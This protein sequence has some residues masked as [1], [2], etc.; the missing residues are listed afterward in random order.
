M[1]S[2][3]MELALSANA[4][5]KTASMVVGWALFFTLGSLNGIA[6]TKS[7][8]LQKPQVKIISCKTD[9]QDCYSRAVETCQKANVTITKSLDLFG[10]IV[11]AT[12]YSEIR[13][14]EKDACTIYF[15]TEKVNVKYSEELIRKM[16][17]RG[18]TQQ[19]IE[20][21][22]WE[23]NKEADATEKTEGV[24]TFK[25]ENLV[26]LLQ[27]WKRGSFSTDDWK[28]V[29]CRGIVFDQNVRTVKK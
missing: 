2:K 26:A 16:E 9:D 4:L 10:I 17:E 29:N 7:K 12:S 1:L 25:T 28:G 20:Q 23:A 15:R 13:G 14:G 5:M 21:A 11:T 22:E 18:Q 24:C 8:R 3:K 27:K 6:Q 19:D